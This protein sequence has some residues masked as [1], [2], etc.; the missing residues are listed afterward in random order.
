MTIST[1]ITLASLVTAVGVVFGAIF[2]IH[3]WFLKQE[4]QDEEIK[5]I[6]E[7]DIPH[8]KDELRVICTGVLACLDG[9]EQQGCNHSVPKA[10][11]QLEEHINKVAHQ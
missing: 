6:K 5:K 10:K 9:L 7:V 11:A 8:L 4:K 2:K 1:I 3:K